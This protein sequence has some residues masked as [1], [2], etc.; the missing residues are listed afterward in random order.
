M[1]KI[2]QEH[3]G[4]REFFLG[5]DTNKKPGRLSNKSGKYKRTPLQMLRILDAVNEGVPPEEIAGDTA[6]AKYEAVDPI[7]GDGGIEKAPVLRTI[8][9]AQNYWR[10]L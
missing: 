10:R 6:T 1:K 7:F 4:L 8:D 3:A 2:K 9:F 5:S